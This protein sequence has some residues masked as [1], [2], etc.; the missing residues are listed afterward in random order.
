MNENLRYISVQHFGQKRVLVEGEDYRLGVV[1][2]SQL[3]QP[4]E[5]DPLADNW[6]EQYSSEERTPRSP[7]TN[8]SSDASQPTP[9]A[10]TLRP[11]SPVLP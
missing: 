6:M 4:G 1:G 8:S 11:E 9:V 3:E 10:E 7:E 5:R 2:P